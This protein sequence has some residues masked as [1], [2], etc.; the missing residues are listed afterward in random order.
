MQLPDHHTHQVLAVPTP[1]CVVLDQHVLSTVYDRLEVGGGCNRCRSWTPGKLCVGSSAAKAR[2][3]DARH[4]TASSA[5]RAI[6]PELGNYTQQVVNRLGRLVS[7]TSLTF[8]TLQT[9]PR[10]IVRICCIS[11]PLVSGIG[12]AKAQR[13]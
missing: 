13:R 3:M 9:R 2:A 11:A 8:G 7:Y 10:A 12:Q 5:M 6:I 4:A 1:R